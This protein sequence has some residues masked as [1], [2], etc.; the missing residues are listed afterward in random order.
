DR[1]VGSFDGAADGLRLNDEVR[2][3]PHDLGYG[4]IEAQREAEV[5]DDLAVMRQRFAPRGLLAGRNEG[6]RP[7]GDLL[8]CGEER[9]EGRVVGDAADGTGSVVD[10]RP[11]AGLLERDRRGQTA[12]A[13]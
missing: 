9:H 8:G 4:L 13:G 7:T 6:L 5:L 1:I 3:V 11:Q 12:G 2:A 10:R